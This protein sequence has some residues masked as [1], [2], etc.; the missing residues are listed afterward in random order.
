[1][2]SNI[3]C[4]KSSMS[5]EIDK[6][7]VGKS[8]LQGFKN[9]FGFV[10]K[11]LK[12][13]TDA[14]KKALVNLYNEVKSGY[15]ALKPGKDFNYN[16]DYSTKMVK[17]LSA[18]KTLC[19]TASVEDANGQ[20]RSFGKWMFKK[21]GEPSKIVTTLDGFLDGTALLLTLYSKCGRTSAI[22]YTALGDAANIC[23]KYYI[24]V[25]SYCEA[26]DDMDEKSNKR[27][28]SKNKLDDDSG[29]SS[30]EEQLN[31]LEKVDEAVNA[32]MKKITKDK[33]AKNKNWENTKDAIKAKAKKIAVTILDGLSSPIW[34]T[35]WGVRYFK[36][37][38]G[39]GKKS[40]SC[41]GYLYEQG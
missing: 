4:N 18:L 21:Y 24:Y 34:G 1:M 13:E 17:A 2:D 15:K 14:A 31:D 35:M 7:K 30:V 38:L 3:S 22:P 25:E 23:K 40:N 20:G 27:P 16:P 41:S 8:R 36:Q 5:E 6:T 32:H 26:M 39:I 28:V 33:I 37:K 11:D 19:D 10:D 29:R 9:M 12:K